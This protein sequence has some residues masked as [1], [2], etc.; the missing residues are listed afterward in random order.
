[1]AGLGPNVPPLSIASSTSASVNSLSLELDLSITTFTTEST[2]LF[3]RKNA[4]S[5]SATNGM[6]GNSFPSSAMIMKNNSTIKKSKLSR[7][8]LSIFYDED[9]KE[10]RKEI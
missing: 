6:E 9:E 8:I 10:V 2:R 4:E 1:M 3:E 5:S 7:A